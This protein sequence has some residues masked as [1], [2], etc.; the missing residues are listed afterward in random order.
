M[1]GPQTAPAPSLVP[2]VLVTCLT[3]LPP[4]TAVSL[5]GI[6]IPFYRAGLI[7]A[8]PWLAFTWGKRGLRMNVFDGMMIVAIGWIVLA[9][10]ITETGQRAIVNGGSSAI[11]IGLSYFLARISLPDT[12]A[13]RRFL[14]YLAPAFLL[15]AGLV[16]LETLG[17]R[18]IVQPFF[19]QVFGVAEESLLLTATQPRFGL[20][21]GAGSFPHPILAGLHLGSLLSLYYL[22]AIRGWPRLA[23]VAASL[24]ALFTLSSSALLMLAG[25]VFAIGY[26]RLTRIVAQANWKLLFAVLAVVLLVLEFGTQRGAVLILLELTALNSWTAYFR[27]LIWEYGVQNVVANPLFGIGFADWVRP[28]WMPP[29]VDNYWLLIAMQYGLPEAILRFSLPFAAACTLAWRSTRMDGLE[30]DML[31]ALAISLM[32]FTLLGFSVSLWNN[33]QAWFNIVT[34]G[35]VSLVAFAGRESISR[36]DP[37][38]EGDASPALA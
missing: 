8:L 12:T 20:L 38:R 1:R 36:A 17:G 4:Q 27:T 7:L 33:T 24:S 3:L 5:G 29:S 28:A 9:L 16:A 37:E 6:V 32:L 15:A 2:L 30:R 13:L 26:D 23:G 14:V 10:S 22:S 11:D 35:A 25:Q 31:R 34:G 18:Y 19:V 21:R